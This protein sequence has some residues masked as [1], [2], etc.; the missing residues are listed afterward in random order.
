MSLAVGLKT[1]QPETQRVKKGWVIIK[2]DPEMDVI[3]ENA[4]FT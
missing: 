1:L 2:S 4:N 3:N